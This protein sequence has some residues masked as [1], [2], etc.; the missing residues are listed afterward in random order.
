M[1]AVA[2]IVAV[3]ELG[4]RS[5]AGVQP[6]GV[7]RLTGGTVPG[8]GAVLRSAQAPRQYAPEVASPQP[9]RWVV[10]EDGSRID[11]DRDCVIGRDPSGSDAAQRGLNPVSLADPD[12][13][14]SRAHVEVRTVNGDVLIVDRGSTTGVYIR[15]P[16]QHDWT[17]IA[18]WEP[19]TWRPGSYIQIGGRILRLHGGAVPFSQR[20]PRV[21]RHHH[22]PRE[23]HSGRAS[24]AAF[25]TG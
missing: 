25:P 23:P 14:M 4:Q 10:L 7:Y 15:E 2:A 11:I 18:P 19:V 21:T 6:G 9:N 3:D 16:A 5:R 17:R 22:A 13:L 20:G 8:D 12:G 24:S 1:P